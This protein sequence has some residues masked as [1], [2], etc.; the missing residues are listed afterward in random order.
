MVN[1]KTKFKE[2]WLKD[3]RFEGWIKMK[4]IHRAFCKKCE[5]EFDVSNKG[6]GSCI[7]HMDSTMH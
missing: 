5:K 6:V 7:A 3:P 2:A 4:T 1:G